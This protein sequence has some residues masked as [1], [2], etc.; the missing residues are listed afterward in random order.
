[1]KA[2]IKQTWNAYLQ[3]AYPSQN[4]TVGCCWPTIPNPEPWKEN[5][6]TRMSLSLGAPQQT[7]TDPCPCC[8]HPEKQPPLSSQKYLP[9]ADK[10]VLADQNNSAG[11]VYEHLLVALSKII[12]SIHLSH[13]LGPIHNWNFPKHRSAEQ[14][15]NLT[16]LEK[17]L[18]LAWGRIGDFMHKTW[19]K[20]WEGQSLAR[21]E[22]VQT[23]HP[24]LT[25]L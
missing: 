5:D 6:H 9:A 18:E 7:P 19:D 17:C 16:L 4:C 25:P 21:Q 11:K 2:E 8:S 22:R 24:N 12:Q 3:S 20:V 13:I 23:L 1:M 10:F 14:R 15:L